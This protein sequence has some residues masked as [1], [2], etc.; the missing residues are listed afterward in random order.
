MVKVQKHIT[1]VIR[2]CKATDA[3]ERTHTVKLK[4]SL[5]LS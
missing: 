1:A 4:L 5:W 2:I 3:L